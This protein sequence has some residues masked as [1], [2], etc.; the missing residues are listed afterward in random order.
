MVET[1]SQADEYLSPEI[2]ACLNN[3]GEGGEEAHCEPARARTPALALCRDKNADRGGPGKHQKAQSI[4]ERAQIMNKFAR[5][6]P[7]FGT[8]EYCVSLF[9]VIDT[10]SIGSRARHHVT[11]WG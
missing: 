6:D 7:T 4:F 5:K 2:E 8:S 1:F 10:G 3:A 9:Y 11:G